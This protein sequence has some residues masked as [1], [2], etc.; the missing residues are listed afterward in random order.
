MEYLDIYDENG[1]YI[2]KEDRNVVHK[3]ALWHNTVHLM[4]KRM[5]LSLIVVK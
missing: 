1:N 3:D 2:G 5:N 4:K